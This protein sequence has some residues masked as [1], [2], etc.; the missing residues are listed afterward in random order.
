M[1][2]LSIGLA[3]LVAAAAMAGAALAYPANTYA[4]KPTGMGAPQS[5]TITFAAQGSDSTKITLTLK[6]EPAH[7]DQPAHIHVGNCKHPGGVKIPLTDVVGGSSVTV[8][9]KPLSEVMVTGTSVNVHKSAKE[10][11]VYVACGDVQFAMTG[12]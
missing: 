6:G 7:A 3:V 11:N 4:V 2:K 5:G 9:K 8:V 12:K 1:H 10:L